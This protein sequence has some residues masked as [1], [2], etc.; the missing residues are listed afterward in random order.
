MKVQHVLVALVLLVS[1]SSCIN[2]FED[3]FLN[4]DGSG[5]YELR[6]DL[7]DMMNNPML[8]GLMDEF[9]SD[10]TAQEETNIFG[11]TAED[12]TVTMLALARES[13]KTI[14]RPEFWEKVTM[15]TKMDEDSGEFYL[16]FTVP[17]EELGDVSYFYDNFQ[18]YMPEDGDNEMFGQGGV[19]P[20]A[21]SFT[22]K[23]RE[24]TRSTR[25]ADTSGEMSDM[26]EQEKQMMSMFF[27]GATYETVYHLP[28]RVKKTDFPNAAV[29]GKEITVRTPLLEIL[30]GNADMDGSVTF[31]RR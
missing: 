3:I 6:F 21:L 1:A 20:S 26:D 12:T 22:L 24:L 18:S 31:R 23:R 10:S 16:K 4:K 8:E 25:F 2:I 15:R 11:T 17:F 27:A 5:R 14:E 30:E 19:L 28:G 7:S 29:N 9:G 13:G